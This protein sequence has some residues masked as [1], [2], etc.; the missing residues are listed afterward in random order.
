MVLS[1]VKLNVDC[2]TTPNA[3]SQR[4]EAKGGRL[5]SEQGRSVREVLERGRSVRKGVREGERGMSRRDDRRRT[6]LKSA[7]VSQ[8]RREKPERS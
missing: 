1:C 7:D 3:H 5:G 4:Q 2:V 8:V 6:G